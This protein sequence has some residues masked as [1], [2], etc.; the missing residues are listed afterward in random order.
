MRASKPSDRGLPA[1]AAESATLSR[2]TGLVTRLLQRHSLLSLIVVLFVVFSFAAPGTFPTAPNLQGLALGQAVGLLLAMSVLL[3]TTVGEFDLSVAYILGLSAVLTAKLSGDEGLPVPLVIVISIAAGALIGTISGI[4]VTRLKVV[5]LIATLGVGLAVSGLTVGI[6][7]GQ[8]L[9]GNI[10][11]TFA[12]LARTP[13]LGV[14]SAVWIVLAIA[15]VI[16]LMLT[17]TPVGSKIYATGGSE[18]VA[19][20]V[21]IRVRLLKGAMFSLAGAC[22]ALAGILQLGLAGAAN[23]SFGSNLL[24][25]A[26]AAV[27]L[28]STTVRPGFFNVAGTLLAVVLLAVGF[29][30]LSLLGAPFWVEPVF[31]GVALI[32]GIVASRWSTISSRRRRPAPGNGDGLASPGAP[33]AGARNDEH[34]SLDD[35]V[36]GAAA[37]RE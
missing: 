3:V 33:E 25:P 2:L 21:G 31:D 11:Q 9:S 15:V 14:G 17:K 22:A 1:A 28:G 37:V 24:L 35:T 10:P 23:P 12:V 26:F 30:G 19:R 7:G 20:M 4:V 34:R 8:T 29:S 6:S 5:S 27:F 13:I 32:V 18:Q 36:S 16:Y